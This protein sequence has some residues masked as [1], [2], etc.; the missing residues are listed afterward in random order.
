MQVLVLHIR[1]RISLY[2]SLDM[3]LT[4]YDHAGAPERCC[5]FEALLEACCVYLAHYERMTAAAS[6][7]SPTLRSTSSPVL[8]PASAPNVR[9]SE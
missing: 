5:G 2:E 1:T 4:I 8:A 6:P 7:P 9:A 3:K